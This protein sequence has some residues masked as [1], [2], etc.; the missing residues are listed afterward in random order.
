[1]RDQ[2]GPD[3][4][5]HGRKLPLLLPPLPEFLDVQSHCGVDAEDRRFHGSPARTPPAMPN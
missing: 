1:V 4:G 5:W 2:P 3:P